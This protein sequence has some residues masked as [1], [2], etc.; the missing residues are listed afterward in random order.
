[1]K[2]N[3]LAALVLLPLAGTLAQEPTLKTE[4]NEVLVPVVVRD[5]NG[6][7]VANLKR[8]DFQLFDD[9]R[10][11]AIRGFRVEQAG[12]RIATDRSVAAAGEKTEAAAARLVIPD[13]SITGTGYGGATGY[14]YRPPDPGAMIEVARKTGGTYVVGR[15]DLD[16]GFRS[17]ATP[18][19]VYVLGFAPTGKPDGSVHRLKIKMTGP[20]KVSLEFRKEYSVSEGP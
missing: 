9:D 16:F 6:N 20:A 3:V 12:Q 7:A 1:M 8:E 4:A 2:S 15:N 5:G 10:P 14:F 18:K 17:L 19:Y 13:H 11:Q